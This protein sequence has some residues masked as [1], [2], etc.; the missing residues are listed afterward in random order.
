MKQEELSELL[1]HH[2]IKPTANRILVSKAL[3][4]ADRP[5]TLSELEDA[6]HTID[7]SGIFRALSLFHERHLVHTI[8][9][10]GNGVRYELC[11]S[12]ND[13]AD[14]DLHVHFYCERCQ[15]TFCLEHIPIPEV[16]LPEDYR[17]ISANFTI[18]GVCAGCKGKR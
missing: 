3:A 12:H 16:E 9:D 10:S 17:K 2:G 6:L 4:D 5:L 7:K 8:E 15:R 13:D 1:D 18:K 14:D 11:H